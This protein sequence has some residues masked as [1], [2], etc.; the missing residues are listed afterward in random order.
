MAARRRLGR[1]PRWILLGLLVLGVEVLLYVKFGVRD[2]WTFLSAGLFVGFC[3]WVLLL[4][5]WVPPAE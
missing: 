5:E 2:E 4:G 3:G 1:R